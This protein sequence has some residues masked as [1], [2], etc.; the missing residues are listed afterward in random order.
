M[1]TVPKYS[2][3]EQVERLPSPRLTPDAPA[4][5]FGIDLSKTEQIARQIWIEE[6]QKADQIAILDADNQLAQHENQAINNMQQKKGKDAFDLPNEVMNEFDQTTS[7]IA[8]KLSND[9]QAIAFKRYVNARRYDLNRQ[10]QHHVARERAQYDG[11]TTDSF[12]SNERNAA[13]L[14]YDNL[15]RVKLSVDRQRAALIDYGDRNGKP[16]EYVDLKIAETIGKTHAGVIDRMLINGYDLMAKQYYDKNKGEITDEKDILTLEKALNIG[17][18]RGESQRQADTIVLQPNVTYARA[19]ERMRAIKDPAVRDSVE[20][21]INRFFSE[22]KIIEN[23][24]EK[25]R[26]LTATD[27]VDRTMDVNNIS[28]A[29]WAQLNIEQRNALEARAKRLLTGEEPVQNDSKWL[30]FLDLTPTQLA[31]MDQNQLETKYRQYFDRPHWDRAALQW[32]IARDAAKDPKHA[33][34]LSAMQT[35]KDIVF[36]AF[37]RTIGKPDR[38]NWGTDEKSAFLNFEDAA[39]SAV[40]RYELTNLATKRK[41]TDE[42]KQK[43]VNDLMRQKVMIGSFWFDREKPLIMLTDDERKAAYVPV[44]KIPQE[45]K[46]R[47]INLA[48]S[49][50]VISANTDV[51]TA[52]NMLAPRLERAYGAS[53][54][55]RDDE[56]IKNILMGK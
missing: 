49:W 3:T 17:S 6:K 22:Q 38:I 35:D 45:A 52:T 27:I 12:L 24:G 36:N 43:I 16:K 15:D 28:P 32:A 55:G 42:E 39:S 23:D 48:K 53:L 37:G 7:G 26:M 5:A 54:V 4:A 11:E 40:Q 2:R 25:K 50:R 19:L 31:N 18:V 51:T 10:V 47:M 1:P 56:T 21:R 9:T 29:T 44:I 20:D 8:D 13:V 33:P 46:L 14:N 41:A 30:E 34:V